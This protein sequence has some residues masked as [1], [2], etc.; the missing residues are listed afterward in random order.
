VHF[1]HLW[2]VTPPCLCMFACVRV[3][4]RVRACANVRVRACVR[5]PITDDTLVEPFDSEVAA[6]GHQVLSE[7]VCLLT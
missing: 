3:C 5:A 6:F 7:A 1:D 4:V 2:L